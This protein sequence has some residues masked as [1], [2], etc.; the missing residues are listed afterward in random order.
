MGRM[1]GLTIDKNKLE[2]YSAT[3]T[4]EHKRLEAKGY[5]FASRPD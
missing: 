2:R 3:L 1:P 4:Q 5:S